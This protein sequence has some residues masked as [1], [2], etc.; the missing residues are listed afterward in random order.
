[1]FILYHNKYVWRCFI[2]ATKFKN[3]TRKNLA[4]NLLFLR[5]KHNLSQEKLAAMCDSS[6]TYI[7]AIEHGKRNAS[8]DFLDSV[9]K[10]FDVP[11]SN[12]L[13]ENETVTPRV[14]VDSKK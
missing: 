5:Y 7:S 6:A 11:S 12:L 14:R 2:I 1:M 3:N 4:N 9:A 13:M 8:V 10:A